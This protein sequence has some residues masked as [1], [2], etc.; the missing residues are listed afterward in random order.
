M[1]LRCK[2][3]TLSGKR[4][5]R[6]VV[7]GSLQCFQH[8]S[9]YNSLYHRLGGIYAIAAV[10]N[11]FSDRI[12]E[13]PLVGKNSPNPH[14]RKWSRNQLDRLPGLKFMRTL[15]VCDVSG[16]PYTF[17]ATKPGKTPLG[18]ENAHKK[19]HITSREFD[20]VAKILRDSLK[21]FKV[22]Q[23]EIKE[24]L[25]AFNAHKKEVVS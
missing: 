8:Q 17:V 11:Y 22:P 18:L 25:G 6:I 2:C 20:R 14:L 1:S 24:V 16:G 12:L 9:S 15:W 13:D 7:K 23:T 4:C 5:K 19:F 21:H 10:V 3:T